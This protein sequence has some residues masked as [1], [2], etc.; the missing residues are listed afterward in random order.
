MAEYQ[1]ALF[2]PK[3]MQDASPASWRTAGNLPGRYSSIEQFPLGIDM[4]ARLFD[5]LGIK[6][7]WDLQEQG[8]T[9][10]F[11]PGDTRQSAID[12]LKGYQ[13]DWNPTKRNE[14]VLKV[15][16][17]SGKQVFQDFQTDTPTW[18]SGLE[19]AA[20]AAAGFGGVGL[21]TGLGPLGG[22]Q[23]MMLGQGGGMMGPPIEAAGGM[24]GPPIEAAGMAS[25]FSYAPVGQ[26]AGFS[27]LNAGAPAAGDAGMAAA[28]DAAGSWA[29]PEALA[30]WGQSAGIGVPEI[31]GAAGGGFG[32]S[33]VGQAI[34]GFLSPVG[35]LQGLG[36]IANVA[37]PIVQGLT[38]IYAANKAAGATN[39]ATTQANDLL[40][41]MYDTT[42]QDNMPGLQARND[43]LG[44]IQGLLSSPQS[45]TGDPGYQFGL[46]QGTKALENGAA[47]RGM[48][49]S[50]QQAKALTQF[51]QDYAGSKMD[52]SVNRLLQLANAGSGSAAN[53][54]NAGSNYA[55]TAANNITSQ[56][57]ANALLAGANGNAV[58]NALNQL[59]AYG[60]SK[61]WWQ[62]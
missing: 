22:L 51:G 9:G 54:A 16:D 19:A 42:R 59:T 44:K 13:F 4:R 45:I 56:G 10:N 15:F 46:N 33:K 32:A 24:M 11:L 14:G 60:N 28:M 12:A 43:A 58:G 36:Q 6:N 29:T 47:A 17:P 39:A 30:A 57:T 48:T 26:E 50:G 18:K 34:N 55:G 49:Y 21:L 52:Q 8:D 27:F 1:N 35:G 40:R 3:I 37:S 7:G 38:G 61:K 5:A 2:N 20:L 25:P 41:Y 62:G 31:A 53:I 23:G